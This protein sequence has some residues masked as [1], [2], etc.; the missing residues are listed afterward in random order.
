MTKVEKTVS[1]EKERKMFVGV[2]WNCAAELK[3]LLTAL[4][5]LFSVVTLLQFLPP[6]FSISST[7]LNPCTITTHLLINKTKNDVPNITCNEVSGLSNLCNEKYPISEKEKEKTTN[8]SSN[9]TTPTNNNGIIKRSF[10][11]YGA[12]AYNFILMSAYRGSLNSFAINGLAS[13]PLI[14]F[15]KPTYVCKWVPNDPSQEPIITNGVK[16]L[17]DWGYGRVYTVVIINCTFQTPIVGGNDGKLHLLATTNGGGDTALNTTDTFVALTENKGDFDD[18]NMKLSNVTPKY[19]YFYCGSSLY[20][21]LSPQRVR[22]WVAY[23]VKFFGEKSHFVIHD[24]GGIHEQVMEV[25]KP[26]IEKGYVTLQDIR[27]QERFDGY[28]HN[29]FLV[30]NDCLHRYRFMTKWMFFF[31]VDEFIFVP[32][33][34]TIKSVLNSLSD[35]TQFTI[36][37]MPMSN[38]LCL[39]EDIRKSYRLD[40]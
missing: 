12:A 7:D 15:G 2:V 40:N 39:S 31:D 13:K 6:R 4:L 28:Y 32:K 37:Q 35:F 10:K 33:K 22:E 27:V 38:G 3:L 24:A 16:M 25:L 36:E 34:S 14:V 18:F 19:D 17:P 21:D 26:W 9:Q 8:S 1:R 23:H 5:L 20:G 29:Q 11:P 30:V